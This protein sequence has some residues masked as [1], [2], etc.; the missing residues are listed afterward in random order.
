[1]QANVWLNAVM[2]LAYGVAL[3]MWVWDLHRRYSQAAEKKM[4][5]RLKGPEIVAGMY[6]I[7]SIIWTVSVFSRTGLKYRTFS[8]SSSEGYLVFLVC[9]Q[10]GLVIS[11]AVLPGRLL[12]A[13]HQ[14]TKQLLSQKQTY[15]RFV[16]HEIRSPL[17]VVSAG[18]EV[19]LREFSARSAIPSEIDL[20]NEISEASDTAIN[21]VNDLL[22]YESMDA[23]LFKIDEFK[24]TSAAELVKAHSLSMI[25]K[26][27]GQHLVVAVPPSLPPGTF[28]SADVHRIEQVVR[29]LVTNACK[30]TPSGGLIT[31]E[32][33]LRLRDAGT[34]GT[35]SSTHG[36]Q[37]GYVQIR[38]IDTGVGIKP[39]NQARVFSQFE[40]FDKSTL[41]SGGGSGLGLWI[42]FNIINCHRGTLK[43]RSEGV[44]KGTVF[45]FD[46]PLYSG[47][48][49]INLSTVEERPRL[50]GTAKVHPLSIK[51]PDSKIVVHTPDVLNEISTTATT[52]VI[53]I[54][55]SYPVTPN[56]IP[57]QGESIAT[58]EHVLEPVESMNAGCRKHSLRFLL[59]DDVASVRKMFRRLLEGISSLQPCVILEVED[60]SEA[61]AAVN[62]NP[63]GYFDCIFMDSVMQNIHG[64]EAVKVLRS[65]GY[66]GV[67]I[68]VT[69]NAMSEDAE[70]F[71][72]SG[73]DKLLFKPIKSAALIDALVPF[74]LGT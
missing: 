39:E 46:L 62:S 53:D 30:F 72:S 20:V 70:S 2:I 10:I 6:S 48:G 44:G 8:R 24:I 69:G 41:Q 57:R 34:A 58:P 3:L 19:L 35:P 23:G 9:V 61:V 25:A 37:C 29:N 4:R 42:S 73:L 33:E 26:R 18:L 22:Q 16:S 15:V 31:V 45:Y 56:F 1:M 47:E 60:G 40:Q 65:S 27:N 14:S 63:A 68:G 52:E 64:P 67:I 12:R 21:I 49:L 71:L 50:P 74:K 5:F 32:T 7:F 66:T 28:L 51:F 43:F 59:V 36:V 13:R 17:A 11:L 55:D 38:V 54:S